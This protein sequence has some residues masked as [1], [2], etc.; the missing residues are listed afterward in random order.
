[1]RHILKTYIADD[2][3]SG[4]VEYALVLLLALSTVT[5]VSK[6]LKGQVSNMLGN[7]GIKLNSGLN[8]IN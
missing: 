2:N 3:G 8:N 1:M 6:G 4:A 7:I 5:I